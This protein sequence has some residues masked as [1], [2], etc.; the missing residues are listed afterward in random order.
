MRP[1]VP[2]ERYSDASCGG[3]GYRAPVGLFVDTTPLRVSRDFRRLW[4]GQSVSFVGTMITS[5]ALPY[6]VFHATGSSLDVG[7]LGV[8]QLAPLLL[9]SV[10]GGAFA[11]SIDKRRLLLG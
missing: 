3:A 7:L 11:D 4:T 9:F 10:V 2:P 1:E 5:A 8:A 6:Q